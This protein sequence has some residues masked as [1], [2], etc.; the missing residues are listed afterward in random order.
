MR[1]AIYLR[2]VMHL[3]SYKEIVYAVTISLV[4]RKEG[5]IELSHKSM[6]VPHFTWF[7]GPLL[8]I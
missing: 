1:V 2:E 4:N 8:N 6:L 5:K 7:F 3:Y